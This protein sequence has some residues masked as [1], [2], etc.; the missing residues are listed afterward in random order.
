MKD[1][2]NNKDY[3]KKPINKNQRI[4]KLSL[5]NGNKLIGFI[6]RKKLMRR[7]TKENF[8]FRMQFENL[9]N[10]KN[11]SRLINRKEE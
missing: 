10:S 4:I 1:L 3:K 8:M 5:K 2:R 11:L 9:R 6:N 7:N